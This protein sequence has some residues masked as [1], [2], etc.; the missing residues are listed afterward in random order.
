MSHSVT[1]G[2]SPQQTLW[3]GMHFLCEESRMLTG[4]SIAYGTASQSEAVLTGRAQETA[5]A[6]GAFVPSEKPLTE[7]SI[8]DLA[9]LSKLFTAILILQL[10]HR[11]AL[12]LNEYV[13]EIV[14]RFIHLRNTTVFDVLCFR[15]CLQTPG[16]IDDAP[17]RDEGLNRLFLVHPAPL[18]PIRIYSDINAMVLKYVIEAKSGMPLAQALESMILRPAGLGD[19]YASVP[20]DAAR[21]CV[22][23]NFEHRIAG[24]RYI[25][26]TDVLPCLPHDPK[27]LLLSQGG[28]DLCGHAGVFS[29]RGDMIRLAQ[30]L[31]GG[32]L[33]PRDLLMEIGRDRTGLD[34]GDGTHRQYLGFQCFSKHPNQ[35]LSEVPE[36]MSH[37]ALGLSGFTGNHLSIDPVRNAFVL[38]LGNRCH[39]RVSNIAPPQ[40][41]SLT[42]YGLAPN[43]T[44]NVAWPDG[45]LVPSSARY[46]YFKDERLHAPIRDRMRELGWI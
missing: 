8:F 29:T 33:L 22:C 3:N 40:G 21:R 7:N 4:V 12:D 28:R 34:H 41:G 26:R 9:S 24:D 23:Y 44:G 14:P 32:E 6:D 19:T 17:D 2:R 38:F 18:P 13:G 43:G 42:D 5:L 37:L 39:G 46:V 16:R 27:A 36:W 11:G 35:H 30:A 25:L 15:A 31:L 1:S 10:V 20:Q 45:R